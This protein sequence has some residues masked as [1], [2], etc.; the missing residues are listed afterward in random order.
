MGT[1]VRIGTCPS[2][3]ATIREPTVLNPI[4]DAVAGYS[5]REAQRA[6]SRRRADLQGIAGVDDTLDQ[7]DARAKD[8]QQ[9]T[10]ALLAAETR[11]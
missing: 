7:I 8:L 2:T 10:A 9:R 6:W 5:R 3:P 4:L 1:L 11:L